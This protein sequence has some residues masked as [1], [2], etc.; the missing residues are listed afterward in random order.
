MRA[1]WGAV[2][3]AFKKNFFYYRLKS[4]KASSLLRRIKPI[5][6]VKSWT[7]TS[8]IHLW[9]LT[10]TASIDILNIFKCLLSGLCRTILLSMTARKQLLFQFW[11]ITKQQTSLTSVLSEIVPLSI[12]KTMNFKVVWYNFSFPSRFP[13]CHAKH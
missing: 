12:I 1:E 4:L 3:S 9:L 10:S 7:A 13:I 2:W 11:N 8:Q 5:F 6:H